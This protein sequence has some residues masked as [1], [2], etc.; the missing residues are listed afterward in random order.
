MH[1]LWDVD[2]VVRS[3]VN[4][5]V[6]TAGLSSVE[7][8][9]GDQR[10][11]LLALALLCKRTSP[12]ANRQHLTTCRNGWIVLIISVRSFQLLTLS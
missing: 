9:P 11:D 10:H 3:I 6:N 1:S 12:P 5:L 7:V 2:D 8:L 4:E